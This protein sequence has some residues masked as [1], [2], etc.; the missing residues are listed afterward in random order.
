MKQDWDDLGSHYGST[1]DSVLIVDVDCTAGGQG[2]CQKMGV[3]GYPTIK[4]FMARQTFL[5]S[6]SLQTYHRY[7]FS[8][9]TNISPLPLQSPLKKKQLLHSCISGSIVYWWS[10]CL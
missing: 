6:L 7:L 10:Y 3:Q 2:T 9:V 8:T 1:H 5:T 4:Y